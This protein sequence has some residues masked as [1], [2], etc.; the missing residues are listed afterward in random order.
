[1]THSISI[2]RSL[3]LAVPM[4][5][6]AIA[7]AQSVT[8]APIPAMTSA[9][10]MSPDGRWIVGNSL[11]GFPARYD[12]VTGTILTMPDGNFASAVS[13]DGTVIVGNMPFPGTGQET[14]GIWREGQGW[15]A[16]G[17]LNGEECGSLSSGYEVSADGSVVVGLGWNSCSGRGF[18]WTEA[19][20]MQ[21]LDSLGNG[22]NRASVVSGDGT[23]IGGFAQ[24]SF[25]RTPVVWDPSGAGELLDP[26]NGD[27][28]GEVHG[29]SDDGSILLGS[30]N[31]DA[32]RWDDGV[33]T[34]IGRGQ[35]IPGWTG[36]AMD[37]AD[38]GTIIG[39]D[40]LGGNRRAWIVPAGETEL[41]LLTDWIIAN[42]GEVS[43]PFSMQVAHAISADGSL[44]CG[45][46]IPLGAW[47]VHIDDASPCPADLDGT[48]EVGFDDL[49][50]VLAAWG[51]DGAGADLEA[52]TDVVDFSDLIVVL[53]SWGP[54]P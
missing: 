39:F 2:G 8:W 52:P 50:A 34:V 43:D 9:N 48:G 23:I 18:I 40:F 24:G 26:P 16:L 32:V 45:H 46:G 12:S 11:S 51:T 19:T 22:N 49:L 4:I 53:A 10:D 38:N 25:T 7:G 37:I 3:T 14:A 31:G 42:G 41:V 29:I 1:M 30:W 54:C 13:D 6:T 44:I 35:L 20:G 15:T 17:G 33:R 47:M 27:A 5:F 28:I 36:I 21:S